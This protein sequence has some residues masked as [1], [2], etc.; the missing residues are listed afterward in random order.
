[1]ESWLR[2]HSA[3]G[4]RDHVQSYSGL[5]RFGHI[6]KP[7]KEKFSKYLKFIQIKATK[8]NFATYQTDFNDEY[9]LT[10]SS[11]LSPQSLE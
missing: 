3:T 2:G 9:N 11:E 10:I 8:D 7:V 4:D 6:P 5:C 1:M